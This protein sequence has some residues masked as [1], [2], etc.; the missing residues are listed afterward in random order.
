MGSVG[1]LLTLADAPLPLTPAM[2]SSTSISES[3]SIERDD[4]SI[5]EFATS[6]MWQCDLEISMG[7]ASSESSSLAWLKTEVGPTEVDQMKGSKTGK[8]YP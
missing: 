6:Y 2:E 7:G 3:P 8:T 1:R 5:L 4:M